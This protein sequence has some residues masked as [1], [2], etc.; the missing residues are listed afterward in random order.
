MSASTFLFSQGEVVLEVLTP[1]PVAG[2]YEFTYASPGSTGWDNVPNLLVE[3]EA[4]TGEVAIARDGTAADTLG[5]EP[6][7]NGAEI[8]GKI[9]MIYRGAC[10]FALK[11]LHCYEAG[12]IGVL[13]INNF[14]GAPPI[15]PGGSDVS[16]PVDIAVG[17]TTFEAGAA[18]RE[19]VD[20]GE[21]TAF[22]GLKSFENNLS[23]SAGDVLRPPGA[24][25]PQAIAGTSAQFSVP[26]GS[27]VG[28]LGN[29]VQT[30]V[31]VTATIE[32]DGTEVYNES[33]TVATIES[34]DTVFVALPTFSQDEYTI[35]KYTITYTV[36]SDNDEEFPVDNGPIDASIWISEDVFSF[37]P[38]DADGVGTFQQFFRA[39]T[40][41]GILEHCI[42]FRSP[43]ASNLELL[44]ITG[45]ATKNAADG[46]LT[47]VILSSTVYEWN[48]EFEG[49]AV[50]YD[51]LD[52]IG[53]GAEELQEGDAGLPIY[54]PFEVP[55]TLEDNQ[56]YLFCHSVVDP[57]VFIGYAP[58]DY[59]YTSAQ[60]AYNAPSFPLFTETSGF[61]NGFGLD[62][63]PGITAHFNVI[64]DPDATSNIENI[65]ITPFPNP[66]VDMVYIPYTGNAR[67]AS[68][69]VFDLSGRLVKSVNANFAGENMMDVNMAGVEN[70]TY[71][72]DIQFD[73]DTRSTF[74]VVIVK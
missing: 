37:S 24:A 54:M 73:N 8:D 5:C 20:A 70:G 38:L 74:K 31:T 30:N 47:G 43:N 52:P 14:A 29:A 39:A 26:M 64:G 25:F 10:A 58:A 13:I 6:L 35:G 45:A 49:L 32:K 7:V 15:V 53:F 2:L 56:R 28:N 63:A 68:I 16:V 60:P 44:G 27:F 1:A 57:L 11:A 51:A 12:A 33:G 66:S 4:V 23:I 9:A 55:I 19:D 46:P 40:F 72:F 17:M 69:N 71:V 41:E 36:D 65:D 18:I 61:L 59:N 3:A 67:T 42:H 50:S 62:I 48:D 22:M 21:V 34:G